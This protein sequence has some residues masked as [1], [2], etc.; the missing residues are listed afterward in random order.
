MFFQKKVPSFKQLLYKQNLEYIVRLNIACIFFAASFSTP[1][2]LPP[3][4]AL[5]THFSAM[6]AHKLLEGYKA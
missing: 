2:A 1:L 4:K 5:A 6:L 3:R